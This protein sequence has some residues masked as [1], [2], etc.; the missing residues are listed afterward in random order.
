MFIR[1]KS[2]QKLAIFVFHK[3][4]IILE[5]VNDFFFGLEVIKD[6]VHGKGMHNSRKKIMECVEDPHSL[7]KRRGRKSGTAQVGK[8]S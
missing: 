4:Y 5:A 6:S 2:V 8:V 3:L 7:I 1:Y